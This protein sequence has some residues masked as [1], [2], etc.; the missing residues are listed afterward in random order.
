MVMVRQSPSQRVL[1]KFSAGTC[2][3]KYI[4]RERERER[5]RDVR[6]DGFELAWRVGVNVVSDSVK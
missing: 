3:S 4:Y 6:S 1:A 5:E 2:R